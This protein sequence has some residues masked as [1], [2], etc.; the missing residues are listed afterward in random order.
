MLEDGHGETRKDIYQVAPLPECERTWISD[1]D[2]LEARA[3]YDVEAIVQ[4]SDDDV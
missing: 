4:D 1:A 3:R 2:L